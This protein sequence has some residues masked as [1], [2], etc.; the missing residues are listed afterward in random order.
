MNAEAMREWLLGHKHKR[1][2]ATIGRP[3]VRIADVDGEEFEEAG[4]G[5]LLGSGN[6]RQQRH[7]LPPASVPK[8][9]QFTHAGTLPQVGSFYYLI[10]SFIMVYATSAW[11]PKLF[12]HLATLPLRRIS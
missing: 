9:D 3:R 7:P 6:N 12:S 8:N 5:T 4:P 11:L 1:G 10:T 2:G